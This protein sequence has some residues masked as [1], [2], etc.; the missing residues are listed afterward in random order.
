MPITTLLQK[1]LSE[2]DM[3]KREAYY[4]Q[5]NKMAVDTDCVATPTFLKLNFKAAQPN[6][7]DMGCGNIANEFLPERA[8]LK[9]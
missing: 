5:L 8:W 6:L 3:A 9:K 4:K 1:M 7:I 2:T